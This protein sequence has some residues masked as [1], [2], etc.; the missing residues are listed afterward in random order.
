MIKATV[1]LQIINKAMEISFGG[2]KK[3]KGKKGEGY[4][5]RCKG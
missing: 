1:S 3:D 4:G 5:R 2:V